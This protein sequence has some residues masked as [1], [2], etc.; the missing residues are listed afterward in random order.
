MIIATSRVRPAWFLVLAL[1]S[2]ACGSGPGTASQAPS[3]EAPA[4]G[5][6]ASAAPASEAP[7]SQAPQPSTGGGP[8]GSVCDLV[9]A[10]ELAGIF[11]VANVASTV[12]PGPPDTCD[13]QAD[14]AP[15]AAIVLVTD[16]A[17]LVFN[18]YATGAEA[19]PGFGDRAIYNAETQ[20]FIVLKGDVV[21]SI[22]VFSGAASDEERL[23]LQKAIA[24]VAAARM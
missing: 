14:G 11:G 3:S 23:E 20:L 12:I 2:A 15:L 19:Y 10:A 17:E 16:Q 24:A 21:V 18:A 9:T 22:A 5:A 1:V 6:P 7:A 4:S 8:T 13:I